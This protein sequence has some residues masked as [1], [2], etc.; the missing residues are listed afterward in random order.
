MEELLL[1]SPFIIYSQLQSGSVEK[2]IKYLFTITKWFT[3][4]RNG[5]IRSWYISSYDGAN[6]DP[7][8]P[9]PPPNKYYVIVSGYP[10]KQSFL[11]PYRSSRNMV[12]RY[13]MSQFENAP[14]L[15]NKQE[16]FNCWHA[17]LRSVI[18][19]TFWV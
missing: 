15:R 2:L 12:I 13:H 7:E 14:P 5:A 18:K 8:F 6:N 17:S 11:V 3:Y 10:N 19:M 16:F 1:H 9:L 4:V